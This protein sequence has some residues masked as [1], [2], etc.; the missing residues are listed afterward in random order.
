MTWKNS[1]TK[2]G[3][4]LSY[5][6]C[7]V[8]QYLQ[9]GPYSSLNHCTLDRKPGFDNITESSICIL[10]IYVLHNPGHNKKG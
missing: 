10:T 3:T 9:A 5:T 6:V 8:F 7:F 2:S 1:C 4:I